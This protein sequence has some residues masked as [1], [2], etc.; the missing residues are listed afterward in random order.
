MSSVEW[1]QRAFWVRSERSLRGAC[2]LALELGGE[3]FLWFGSERSCAW[4][5]KGQLSDQKSDGFIAGGNADR[6]NGPQS[7][8]SRFPPIPQTQGTISS[9]KRGRTW[10]STQQPSLAAER[11]PSYIKSNLCRGKLYITDGARFVSLG[12]VCWSY[13]LSFIICLCHYVFHLSWCCHISICICY[14]FRSL[15]WYEWVRS[16]NNLQHISITLSFCEFIFVYIV[17]KLFQS[18][19]CTRKYSNTSQWG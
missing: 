16:Y 7:E 18:C 10:I 6:T 5:G 14:Y 12:I 11:S 2:W 8:G 4:P 9:F 15:Y 17:K 1:N 13:F 19:K 3:R